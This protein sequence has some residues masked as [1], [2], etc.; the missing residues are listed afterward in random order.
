MSNRY[1]LLQMLK[2]AVMVLLVCAVPVSGEEVPLE[3]LLDLDRLTQQQLDTLGREIDEAEARWISRFVGRKT[4]PNREPR[5]EASIREY[6]KSAR[7]GMESIRASAK[8]DLDRWKREL[9]EAKEAIPLMYARPTR[10]ISQAWELH[11][12]EA[13][14]EVQGLMEEQKAV[15]AALYRERE[16]KVAELQRRFGFGSAEYRADLARY[17]AILRRKRERE[18]KAK[19]R[20]AYA[21]ATERL[22]AARLRLCGE[23]WRW[24]DIARRRGDDL[25][26]RKFTGFVYRQFAYD[27]ERRPLVEREAVLGK[28]AGSGGS[29]LDTWRDLRK[30]RL[31][32]RTFSLWEP[33]ETLRMHAALAAEPVEN[34]RRFDDSPLPDILEKSFRIV[35]RDIETG[36]AEAER[37]QR[38]LREAE[39]RIRRATEDYERSE[40]ELNH[41]RRRIET[42]DEELV[43]LTAERDAAMKRS[44][45]I[46][47]LAKT[48]QQQVFE[49][50][51]RSNARSID[52][53][54]QRMDTLKA[55][56]SLSTGDI[57]ERDRL[58][59][60]YDRI[61][62][63]QA[64]VQRKLSALE[65]EP[66]EGAI[67]EEALAKQKDE[68]FW[69]T[70]RRRTQAETESGLAEARVENSRRE[71]LAARREA[72]EVRGRQALAGAPLEGKIRDIW[73]RSADTK[74]TY[75]REESFFSLEKRLAELEK[76]I[77]DAETRC[78]R[79]DLA[80]EDWTQDYQEFSRQRDMA[81]AAL[82]AA[83][84]RSGWSQ[85]LFR[86]GKYAFDVGGDARTFGPYGALGRAILEGI[87]G[88]FDGGFKIVEVDF[89]SAANIDWNEAAMADLPP[90]FTKVVKARD[91]RNGFS[92][93]LDRHLTNDIPLEE[94]EKRLDALAGTRRWLD[95]ISAEIDPL[96]LAITVNFGEKIDAFFRSEAVANLVLAQ[97]RASIATMLYQKSSLLAQEAFAELLSLQRAKDRILAA[98]EP[99]TGLVTTE[100]RDF[101]RDANLEIFIGHDK[102]E[103][104]TLE[105]E[106]GGRKAA[107]VGDTLIPKEDRNQPARRFELKPQDVKTIENDGKGGVR[108]IIRAIP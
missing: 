51:L 107:I 58:L 42:I 10:A 103:Q 84:K 21:N 8:R 5:T 57:A 3:V 44:R 60:E 34:F 23:A 25:E 86:T 90:G 78:R 18:R 48:A 59:V 79:I 62:K 65:T 4:I 45:D 53:I 17:D 50:L 70:M 88:Y 2:A 69:E 92:R 20:Q 81:G 83:M 46:M 52:D 54:I 74:E 37:L 47:A 99:R 72:S 87:L 26:A 43:G 24:M 101:P 13:A 30:D 100:K 56:P 41:Q 7:G 75:F 105:V 6:F 98:H 33:M 15:L 22:L 49:D 94:L 9:P 66:P 104:L 73:I 97:A 82:E 1:V 61:Q 29:V 95:S 96:F 27:L 71:M 36:S 14:Q 55:K 19:M 108:L 63:D 102:I 39:E 32:I 40:M 64:E 35:K 91:W 12:A 16:D 28:G 31:E 11:L 85:T 76:Q 89:A 77:E 80:L 68:A 38:E 93:E 67:R 106:L